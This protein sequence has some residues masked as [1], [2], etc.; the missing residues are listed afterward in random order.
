MDSPSCSVIPLHKSAPDPSPRYADI[1][2]LRPPS[3]SRRLQDIALV[4][5]KPSQRKEDDMIYMKWHATFVTDNSKWRTDQ[6]SG[7]TPVQPRHLQYSYCFCSL[8]QTPVPTNCQAPRCLGP[9]HRVRK[10]DGSKKENQSSIFRLLVPAR[11]LGR[12]GVRSDI[13]RPLA[14]LGR[15]TPTDL[16]FSVPGYSMPSQEDEMEI[17]EDACDR[18]PL[19]RRGLEIFRHSDE[20]LDGRPAWMTSVNCLP[21]YNS[22]ARLVLALA[23]GR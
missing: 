21:F 22:A 9:D 20:T 4:V 8:S 19:A 1:P 5:Y 18:R 16:A 2:C 17:S 10:K 15:S 14:A 23:A 13:I 3:Y 6:L 11:H 7:T 12:Y